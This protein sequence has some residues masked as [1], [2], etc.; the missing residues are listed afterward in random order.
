VSSLRVLVRRAT[1]E[2]RRCG[3]PALPTGLGWTRG[4]VAWELGLP[5]ARVHEMRTSVRPFVAQLSSPSE[6]PLPRLERGRLV[7]VR[8][9]QRSFVLLAPFEGADVRLTG[10]PRRGLVTVAVAGIWRAHA[11]QV[12]GCEVPD[13]GNLARG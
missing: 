10:H 2:L 1:P 7:T 5:L 3:D 9:G 6:G 8:A 11:R 4:A 13:R 12:A